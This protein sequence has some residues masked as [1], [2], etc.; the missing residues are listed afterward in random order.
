ME[1]K[2]IKKIESNCIKNKIVKIKNFRNETWKDNLQWYLYGKAQTQIEYDILEKL[3][4]YHLTQS[5]RKKLRGYFA[6]CENYYHQLN[7]VDF[8]SKSDEGI[9]HKKLFEIAKYLEN[10]K[11][12]QKVT[13]I[14]SKKPK[15]SVK[16]LISNKLTTSST[17]VKI[18]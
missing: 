16:R 3:H 9:F 14:P 11:F 2:N 10:T 4:Y 6:I 13:E 1:D 7:K 5:Q 15:K 17:N 12:N 18:K 8:F